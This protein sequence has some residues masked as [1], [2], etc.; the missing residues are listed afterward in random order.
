MFGRK[1][2][3]KGAVGTLCPYCEYNNP[4]GSET[5]EQCY[6]ELDKSARDQPM[7]TP[8][9]SND[10]IMSLLLGDNEF[11]E[12]AH[13]VV[14]AVLTMDDVTVDVG[15]YD[16]PVPAEDDEGEPVP[17]S[18]EFIGSHGPTLSQ[19]VVATE[20]EEEVELTAADPSLEVDALLAQGWISEA[21]PLAEDGLALAR[22]RASNRPNDRRAQARLAEAWEQV[23]R[24]RRGQGDLDDAH[25]ALEHALRIREQLAEG[26]PSR[27]RARRSELARTLCL[28]GQL[29]LDRGRIAEA[30]KQEEK[31][32]RE[33][34][35]MEAER[36]G[37]AE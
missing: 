14:E 16:L 18:F 9:T 10:D 17:E 32:E 22:Y 37:K 29:D 7:A 6:Y 3:D 24:I 31:A 8:T 33:A 19:T 30:R 28:T 36:E 1:N 4:L 13:E 15:Q 5:C 20:E 2:K 23:A 12:E 21:A 11:E 27:R 34:K 25:S 26:T 35:A